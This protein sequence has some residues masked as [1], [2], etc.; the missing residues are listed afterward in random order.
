MKRALALLFALAL[1]ACGTVAPKPAVSHQPSWSVNVST[2]ASVQNSGIVGSNAA[3][4]HVAP[5]YLSRYDS[6]LTHYGDKLSPPRKAGDRNGIAPE[7][8]GSPFYAQGSRWI[9]DVPARER[10]R[11]LNLIRKAD[12]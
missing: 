2:G 6:M 9:F 3:G 11:A 10:F 12:L 4:F 8:L 5:D 7:P 1:S